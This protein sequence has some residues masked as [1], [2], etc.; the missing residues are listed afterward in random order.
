MF[1]TLALRSGVPGFRT[2]SDRAPVAQ[3]IEHRAVMREVAA[4]NPGRI[5]T[6][7]LKTTEEKVLPL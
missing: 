1:R 4:T 6:Q 3:L 5:N 2:R 7:D